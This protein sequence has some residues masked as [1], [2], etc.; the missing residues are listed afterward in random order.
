MNNLFYASNYGQ[1]AAASEIFL[2][3]VSVLLLL[4][5]YFLGKEVQR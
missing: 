3:E 5:L 2:A 1:L 4:A